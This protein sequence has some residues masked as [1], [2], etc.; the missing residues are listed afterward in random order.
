MTQNQVKALLFSLFFLASTAFVTAQE[1]HVVQDFETW[2]TAS[3]KYKVNKHWRFGISENLRLNT[4][5]STVD[6]HFLELSGT[7][8]P[9]KKLSTNVEW[10]LGGKK[11]TDSFQTFSRWFLSG[12]YEVEVGRLSIKPRVAYQTRNQYLGDISLK[13]VDQHFRY[14]LGIDYNIKNWKLDPEASFE[15]FRHS[16]NDD[17]A[18]FD[19]FRVRIGTQIKI[20]D[21]S[22]L[23]LFVAYEDELNKK[24]PLQATIVGLKYNFSAKRSTK[25]KE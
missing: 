8:K 12:V 20:K 11:R 19:K 5:S 10:R 3:F 18:E 24:Y 17:G 16:N 1:V 23:K 21:A 6:Q 25:D 14:R 22:S 7:F 4:N 9:I 13:E 15:L 2:T